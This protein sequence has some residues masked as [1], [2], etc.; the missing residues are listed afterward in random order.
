MSQGTESSTYRRAKQLEAKRLGIAPPPPPPPGPSPKLSP[1]YRLA[2]L[3]QARRLNLP[4]PHFDRDGREIPALAA[5]PSVDP[6]YGAGLPRT[7]KRVD[8][9]AAPAPTNV[10]PAANAASG[11]PLSSDD[12][13]LLYLADC[14]KFGGVHERMPPGT[15]W[16]SEVSRANWEK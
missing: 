16:S 7:L 10:Q 2:L 4:A 3:R 5:G 8:T 15:V 13:R 11:K 1:E 6:W 14:R 12:L 9:P